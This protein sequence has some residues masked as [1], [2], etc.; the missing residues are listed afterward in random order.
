VLI[1]AAMAGPLNA[2]VNLRM[3]A[4]QPTTITT[5]FPALL[6]AVTQ[7]LA[8]TATQSRPPSIPMILPPY[9]RPTP[10]TYCCRWTA[11]FC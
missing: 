3:A 8:T 9:W 10:S 5:V 2:V 6:L 4:V 11:F 7:A 1:G